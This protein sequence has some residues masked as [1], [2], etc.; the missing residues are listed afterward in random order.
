MPLTPRH[1]HADGSAKLELHGGRACSHVEDNVV[2]SVK[3]HQL[4]L[5]GS[6][7]CDKVPPAQVWFWELQR[8]RGSV[9]GGSP[10]QGHYRASTSSS[11]LLRR[12]DLAVEWQLL[13]PS[14]V[15]GYDRKSLSDFSFVAPE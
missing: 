15:L 1:S 10:L 8:T 14:E 11:S 5:G 9:E 3:S 4:L 12:Q 6:C 2:H 13:F 7:P